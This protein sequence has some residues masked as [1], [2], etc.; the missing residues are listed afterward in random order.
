MIRLKYA[1]WCQIFTKQLNLGFIFICVVFISCVKLLVRS[2]T[3]ND[4]SRDIPRLDI[5]Y[6]SGICVGFAVNN[7]DGGLCYVKL[8]DG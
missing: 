6:D 5:E 2:I 8:I 3:S 7:L 4:F 1:M